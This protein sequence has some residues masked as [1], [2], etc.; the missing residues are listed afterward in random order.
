MI[1]WLKEKLGITKLEKRNIYLT[2][3]LEWLEDHVDSKVSEFTEYTRVDADLG[4]RGNCTII[5]TGVFKNKGYIQ[6]YDV[7]QSE[8]A[9]YV[10]RMKCERKEHLIRNIDG[11][12]PIK[13]FFDI[14]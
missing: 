2:N 12:Y 5:L 1:K 7:P 6:F 11:P 10:E 4:V 8:F 14:T 9:Y 13:A 3:K